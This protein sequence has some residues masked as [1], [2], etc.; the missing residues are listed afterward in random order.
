MRI[1]Y[2]VNLTGIC[3][4]LLCGIMTVE[5]VF[6]EFGE[7]MEICLAGKNYIHCCQPKD[8]ITAEHMVQIMK[9]RLPKSF[10]LLC[11]GN[12]IVITWKE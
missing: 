11:N 8:K 6:F 3:P 1:K 10:E 12:K 4:E 9:N 2:H 5:T 7:T